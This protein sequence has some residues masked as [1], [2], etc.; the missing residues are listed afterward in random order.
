MNL[1]TCSALGL[2]LLLVSCKSTD[3]EYE[4][5]KAQREAAT[6]PAGTAP[7]GPNADPYGAAAANPYGVPGGGGE[8]GAYTPAPPA[9]YQPL[10]SPDPLPGVGGTG[11][12]PAGSPNVPGGVPSAPVGATS[13]HTVAKGES[14]WG[15]AQRYG[16]S[17]DAIKAANGMSDSTIRYGSTIQIPSN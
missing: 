12:P 5:Y 3:P 13:S 6:G 4:A 7:F 10:P 8:V 9:P 2:C 11:Y 1:P 15:L 14:L 17:V 16:T